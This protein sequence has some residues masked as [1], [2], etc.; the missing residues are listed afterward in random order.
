L[1]LSVV[2]RRFRAYPADAD[3]PDG[4][5]D[6]GRLRWHRGSSTAGHDGCCCGPRRPPRTSSKRSTA[7]DDGLTLFLLRSHPRRRTEADGLAGIPKRAKAVQ[8]DRISIHA[9]MEIAVTSHTGLTIVATQNEIHLGGNVFEGDPFSFSPKVWDYLIK[10]FALRSVLDLGSG[11]GHAAYYF[12]KAGLQVL[13]V[14]GLKENCARSAFPTIHVDLT[15]SRV[16]CNVDLVHCQEV[17]EHIEERYLDNLLASMTCGKIIVMTHALPG[18]GGYHHVNEQTTEYWINHLK[19]H[20]CEVLME[21]TNRIRVIAQHEQAM[22]LA[23]T[24][25]ILANK[26]RSADFS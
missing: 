2:L 20:Q 4:I 17:V 19:K 22:Y 21:D 15:Q 18:Q 23:K 25:L 24:G 7:A 13:A 14:D 3:R 5:I 9:G 8:P 26:S 16:F 1:R 6:S 12:H 10:R 11:M